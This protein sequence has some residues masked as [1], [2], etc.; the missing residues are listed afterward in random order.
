MAADTRYG[1]APEEWAHFDLVLGLGEYLLPV[2]SNPQAAI[3]GDSTLK[4]LGK[5]P[6]RYKR[7]GT[8]VGFRDWTSYRASEADIA[9]WAAVPDYGMCLQTHATRALDVDVPDHDEAQAIANL[10]RQ[11]V[12]LPVRSRADSAKWLGLLDVPGLIG[13]RRIITAHGVIEFL[14]SGQQCLISG[15]HE[16][17]AR[18]EWLGGLPSSIPKLSLE[19]FE[20]LWAELQ[21]RFGVEDSTEAKPSTKVA[22]LADAYQADPVARHL[23]DTGAAL[24]TERDGRIHFT[25]PWSDLHTTE[26]SESATTYWPAHTG[27]YEYGH[28]KCQHAHCADRTDQDFRDALGYV[29]AHPDV[30]PIVDEAKPRRRFEV[31]DS[32]EFAQGPSP[33][34]LVKRLLPRAGLIILFGQSG[35]GKSFMA[36]DLAA[37]VSQGGEWRGLKVTQGRVVYIVA[38]GAGDFRSRIQA[39][40]VQHGRELHIGL[41]PATPNLLN[42]DHALELAKEIGRADL[43]VVDTFAQVT[44]GGDEN[45]AKDI[46][47]AL[48]HCAGL[49]RATGA[50]VLLVHHSG[51]DE[52]KGARGHSSLKAAADAELE[53]VRADQQRSL[54]VTKMKGGRDGAEYGFRLTDVVVGLDD[55]GEAIESCVVE[56]TDGRGSVRQVAKAVR[57]SVEQSVLRV[58]QSSL[59]PMLNTDLI[60][61]VAEAMP[62]DPEKRDTRSYRV[63]RAI[64]NLV[65]GG[66]LK[67][68]GDQISAGELPA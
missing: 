45:S 38:E 19:Q 52:S 58:V 14:A 28:F 22:T 12:T 41:I 2:V 24:K 33:S 30:F 49:H 1:A 55:D 36:L 25:C 29:E 7:D 13:K 26:S 9:E 53:V 57:G 11:F 68:S 27:G 10:V 61:Q 40:Q 35:S 42:L 8:V 44:A 31:V 23:I 17:G 18:Y 48:E 59:G 34:W 64:E 65:A 66:V 6:S 16:S 3:S 67:V 63:L 43:I 5:V 62:R 46:G 39:W 47:R 20:V 32:S 50:T 21:A 51:K 4:R 37:A 54:C 56:A 15:R 60:R